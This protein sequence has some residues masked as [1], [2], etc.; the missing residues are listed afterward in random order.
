MQFSSGEIFQ[1]LD[2][3]AQC[4]LLLAVGPL[5]ADARLDDESRL[6]VIVDLLLL[7]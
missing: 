6:T 7:G 1:S 4:A 5:S 3:R 2:A